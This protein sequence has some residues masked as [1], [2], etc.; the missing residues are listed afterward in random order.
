MRHTRGSIPYDRFVVKNPLP[1][2]PSPTVLTLTFTSED[3]NAL[4]ASTG[5]MPS[6]KKGVYYGSSNP[7][8]VRVPITGEQDGLWHTHGWSLLSVGHIN[9]SCAGIAHPGLLLKAQSSLLWNDF[10]DN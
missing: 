3:G 1:P 8:R 7:G 5:R 2:P 10:E 6:R 9:P 4:A